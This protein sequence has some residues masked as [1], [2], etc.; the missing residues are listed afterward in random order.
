[1]LPLRDRLPFRSAA[2]ESAFPP[3]APLFAVILR[4]SPPPCRPPEP[5]AAS[6]PAVI[7]SQAQRSRR[8]P[9]FAFALAA[10]FLSVIPAGN[11]RLRPTTLSSRPKA[12]PQ[13]RDPCIPLLPSPLPLH[14]SFPQGTCVPAPT[15]SSRPKAKPQR[16]DPVF[17]SCRY[18]CLLSVIPAG[19]PRSPIPL[20]AKRPGKRRAFLTSE[21]HPLVRRHTRVRRPVMIPVRNP[22]RIPVLLPRN[23]VPIPR[24]QMPS[25][26]RP[27]PML[28]RRNPRLVSLRMRRPSRRNLPI[29][30][31]MCNPR[32]LPALPRPH[33]VPL[34]KRR[35]LP[36]SPSHRSH[37]HGRRQ[38]HH[39]HLHNP[40]HLPKTRLPG[41]SSQAA[42]PTCNP[43]H[44][45]PRGC[46]GL[47]TIGGS[48]LPFVWLSAWRDG[49]GREGLPV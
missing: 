7:L 37:H 31:P 12:K 48:L 15:L 3:F 33:R 6:L 44:L 17:R 35:L 13:R 8:T 28:L 4:H 14:L 9:V 49:Q 46:Y 39:G 25:I 47:V 42:A 34:L 22:P 26:R 24:R 30:H 5:S 32:L 43:I 36:H 11:L 1:M 10:A 45:A 23:R 29:P 40:T 38:K 41:N 2:E 21:Q 20:N 18:P 16:R 19:N 27:V